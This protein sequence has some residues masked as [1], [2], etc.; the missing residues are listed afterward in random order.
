VNL[1]FLFTLKF[2]LFGLFIFNKLIRVMVIKKLKEVNVSIY[3]WVIV[4]KRYGF[5][6]GVGRNNTGRI[7]SF[8]LGGGHKRLFRVLT[9]GFIGVRRCVGIYFD[10]NRTAFIALIQGLIVMPGRSG[11]LFWVLAPK[12]MSRKAPFNSIRFFYRLKLDLAESLLFFVR[13]ELRYFV[14][15]QEIHSVSI[16]INSFLGIFVRSAG[17]SALISSF[18]QK[19]KIVILLL[20]SGIHSFIANS[21]V[22]TR[23]RVSNSKHYLKKLYKAGQRRWL[24]RRPI[25]RGVAINPVDHPHGGRTNGGRPSVRPWGKLAKAKQTVLFYNLCSENI[26]FSYKNL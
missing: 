6:R 2:T 11:T 25:V 7:T 14:L 5:R 8:H 3:R 24:G 17:C 12:G 18:I 21:C 22:G 4:P 16:S 19:S 1:G 26:R 23:G 20:P 10:P 15:Q 13:K 9:W